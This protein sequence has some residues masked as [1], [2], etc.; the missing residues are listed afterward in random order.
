[1]PLTIA[2][3]MTTQHSTAVTVLLAAAVVPVASAVIINVPADQ[4]TIQ[5]GIVAA[6]NG[7]EIVVAPG[8]YFETINFLGKRI[9]L[10]SSDGADVT[11][12][13]AQGMGTVVTCDNGEGTFS[14]LEG[15]TITGGFSALGA[16]MRNAGSSPTVTN[17]TFSGNAG[18][19]GGGMFNSGSATVTNC[20]FSENSAIG[21]S[22]GGGGMYNGLGSTPTVTNCKFSRN[23]ADGVNATGGGMF[24]GGSNPTVTNCSFTANTAAYRGGGM[25][26]FSNSSP[27]VTNC[28]FDTNTTGEGGGG[29][30]NSSGSSPT[31]VNCM[32]TG[33][34]ADLGGGMRNVSAASVRNCTFVRNEATDACI[35]NSAT[36]G[37][38][39][40]CVIWDNSPSQIIGPGSVAYSAV[41]GGWPGTGN[42]DADPQFVDPAAGNFHLLPGSPCIDAANN[43]FVPAG[44]T[45]DLDGNPRFVDDPFTVDT[46]VGDPPIVDMGAHELCPWDCGGDHDGNVGILDFLGLLSQWGEHGATCDF[47]GDA[48]GITDLLE[49]LA[50]WGRCP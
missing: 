47:D 10:R 16:G 34:R 40:N 2:I 33:N 43:L 26:N 3:R 25:Y 21:E 27:T 24:N 48:V 32:F 7:D 14:V 1:V 50:S 41:E 45:T 28:T 29:M 42:I 6:V 15:F 11:T 22:V 44:I 36:G 35:S 20:T 19:N 13:D 39:A 49:L 23:T 38:I 8:T 9:T 5:A 18:V 46:G 37:T 12:I 4:P 17:C 31:V 30:W